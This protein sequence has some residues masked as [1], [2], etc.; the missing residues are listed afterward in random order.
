MGNVIKTY[1]SDH[2]N[3]VF[4]GSDLSDSEFEDIETADDI[5]MNNVLSDNSLDAAVQSCNK[6]NKI[7]KI[8]PE[9]IITLKDVNEIFEQL[10]DMDLI[11]LLFLLDFNQI[12]LNRTQKQNA[13]FQWAT[14]N[15]RLNEQ[16]WQRKLVEAL[17][18]IQ[19]F[20]ILKKYGFNKTDLKNEYFP[21]LEFSAKYVN[22]F[23]KCIYCICNALSLQNEINFLNEVKADFQSKNMVF[24]EF[25]Q[26]ELYFIYWLKIKYISK[27]NLSN[28]KQIFKILDLHAPS[29]KLRM[30]SNSLD[31]DLDDGN[32]IN[33]DNGNISDED[34]RT[35]FHEDDRPIDDEFLKRVLPPSHLP[36]ESTSQQDNVKSSKSRSR[37]SSLSPQPFENKNN[38]VYDMSGKKMLLV[39]N[40]TAFYNEVDPRYKHLLPTFTQEQLQERNG[41]EK[42]A[43]NLKDCFGNLGFQV[44]IQNN[45]TH[46]E[47]E[48]CI[49]TTVKQLDHSYSCLFV[50]ILSHG[51]KGVV[52]GVNSCEVRVDKIR[53]LMCENVFLK[54]KP[55]VLILQSCQGPECQSNFVEE[56]EE[57]L[58]TDFPVQNIIEKAPLY[59]ANFLTCWSTVPG[60]SSIRNKKHGSWF[61]QILCEKINELHDSTHF[62]DI[63]TNVISQVSEKK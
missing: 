52:Y 2:N 21:N 13:L 10:D 7:S 6:E 59:D 16:K 46:L 12:E 63:L 15:V 62:E 37:L 49:K 27:R 25:C 39:I 50:C 1:F 60:Y 45:L 18:I 58:A 56:S 41:S 47:L 11:S 61:I 19:N 35:I 26:L 48:R 44:I 36:V 54:K 55:K 30:F 22:V 3:I 34:D 38:N 29:E 40:Q 33:E 8:L 23:R 9:K 17:T 43:E 57:D 20:K 51:I 5:E 24:K 32:K 4:D 42:D 31:R 14:E 53:H 28:V